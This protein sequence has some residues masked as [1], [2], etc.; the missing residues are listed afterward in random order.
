MSI[1]RCRLLV[2]IQCHIFGE[3]GRSL[4]VILAGMVYGHIFSEGWRAI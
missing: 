2:V 3:A 4:P 1:I